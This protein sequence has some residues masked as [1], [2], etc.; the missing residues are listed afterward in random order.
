MENLKFPDGKKFFHGRGQ[1]RRPRSEEV[2]DA[3]QV[4]QVRLESLLPFQVT[5]VAN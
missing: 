2:A 5:C 1:E 3:L 4:T